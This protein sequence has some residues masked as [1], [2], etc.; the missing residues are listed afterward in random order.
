MGPPPHA[1]EGHFIPSP[2]KNR[3]E[4]PY[5]ALDPAD[6]VHHRRAQRD[7]FFFGRRAF[8]ELR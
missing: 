5:P 3:R 7:A 8:L 2:K 1:A 4:G 6:R